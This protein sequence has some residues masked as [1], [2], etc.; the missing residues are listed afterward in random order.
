ME[1][2]LHPGFEL[3]RHHCLSD[4]VGNGGDACFILLS[5]PGVV[6]LGF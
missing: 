4:S 3:Q 5:F 6:R 1:D 2:L